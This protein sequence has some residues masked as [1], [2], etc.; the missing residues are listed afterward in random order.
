MTTP[1]TGD[2]A[3]AVETPE[4]ALSYQDEKLLSDWFGDDFKDEIIKFHQGILS[5]PAAKP[6]V[7]GSISSKAFTD[8]V[9]RGQIHHNFRRIFNSRLETQ[10][11]DDGTIKIMAA[12][13]QGN[14]FHKG[15]SL[16]QQQQQQRRQP[17]GKV[18]WAELGGEYLHFSL[19]K[20]NKD[21]MEV[22]RF[23]ASRTRVKQN[24]FTYAGTKDRRAVTVQR[25]SIFRQYADN[26][27]RVNRDLRQARIGDFKYEKHP[28]ELG[29][30]SGN[31][32]HITLRDCHFGDDY[33]MDD[34]A[35]L[36]FANEVV[37]QAVQHLQ[38]NGFLNYFGLQRF[39]TFGTG[40][41]EVGI[42]IL[43]GDFEGAVDAI[44]QYSEE[45][46]QGVA[47]SGNPD[48]KI[49]R[50]DIARARAIHKFKTS[51]KQRQ[52]SIDM[53]NKFG[54]EKA[55]V[56]HLSESR[57]RNDYLGALMR[58]TRNLRTMYVHAYQSL[59]WNMVASERW[60]R[61]GTKVIKGDLVLVDTQAAKEA[62][63]DDV[64]ENGE[65]VV[66]PAYD[67]IAV[68]HDDIYQRA[69]PLTEEEAESG[70]FTIFDIVL[71]TPGFDVEYPAN[72]IG[73]YYKEFMASERGG[74]LDPANMRRPQKD[75]SLSGSYRKLMAQVGQDLSY[76]VRLYH[77]DNEQLVE[78]DLEKLDKSR[79]QTEGN[80]QINRCA[81]SGNDRKASSGNQSNDGL[82]KPNGSPT[83]SRSAG[84]ANLDVQRN[85]SLYAGTA[86]HNAWVDLPAKLAAEDKARV[87][88][89]EFEELHKQPINP[90][91]IKQP[92]FKETWIQTDADNEGRRTGF[93]STIIIGGEDDTDSSAK[94]G[95]SELSAH[96]PAD[97]APAAE[98]ATEVDVQE[99]VLNSSCSVA[100]TGSSDPLHVVSNASASDLNAESA[101]EV[102]QEQTVLNAAAPVFSAGTAMEVDSQQVVPIDPT[103][104]VDLIHG[105][106][107]VRNPNGLFL[108]KTESDGSITL[109][110]A[111]TGQPAADVFGG[112]FALTSDSDGGFKLRPHE[113]SSEANSDNLYAL[114]TY[115]DGNMK[116]TPYGTSRK[117]SI[118]QI[119]NALEP[120]PGGQSSS[121]IPVNG[122]SE[123]VEF[124]PEVPSTITIHVSETPLKDDSAPEVTSKISVSEV[125][126]EDKP[127]PSAP[128]TNEALNG[129][130]PQTD[131]HD[132][133]ILEGRGPAKIAVI[134]KFSLG[135]SQYATMA[136]RELM[137]AGGVKTYIPEFTSGN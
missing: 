115:P 106:P 102:D 37:S 109:L 57:T 51:D 129:E 69:R 86:Q 4:F 121:E 34:S 36:Q 73:D 22:I 77:E 93:R 135:S 60:A 35:R 53:P 120:I 111:P 92:I 85:R 65:V 59:V 64:D 26:L 5:K 10:S 99:P 127:L 134:L 74:G 125:I 105:Q 112:I 90:D 67:D 75:F 19:Y 50:D 117:R 110:Q 18:G 94:K 103:P 83:S 81:R 1:S 54:A 9:L 104:A 45:V 8:R 14:N 113:S 42:K 16:P 11:M 29:E 79:P 66:H 17:S 27:A 49:G 56:Q 21:T 124:T 33:N 55:I 84:Q 128:L 122:I 24:A 31:Q 58:V 100:T 20:E 98:S 72:D 7:F 118:E 123:A 95:E 71:P 76:D 116:L 132:D 47:T 44:L 43:R 12:A 97:P 3:K 32:F 68:S 70:Q 13:K 131:G 61:Y 130:L 136:L 41:D 88:A 133:A 25:V 28:L 126:V 96:I 108:I 78:T 2:S 40:T 87:E 101:M 89:E 30:L 137:K 80:S 119:S 82:A 107:N 6:S 114:S 15:Q 91:E 62:K 46:G 39:G 23:L 63:Q 52:A 38:T 48:E